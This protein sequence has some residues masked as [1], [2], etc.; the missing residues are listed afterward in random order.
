MDDALGFEEMLR[1]YDRELKRKNSLESKASYILGIIS[2]QTTIIL[3]IF[4]NLIIKSQSLNKNQLV[5]QLS[6][7]FLI[8]FLIVISIIFIYCLKVLKITNT[9]YP[10]GV[11]EN[12]NDLK[13][14]LK[15]ENLIKDLYTNYFGAIS[16][17]HQNIEK[18]VTRMNIIFKLISF[19]M[20][21][22]LILAILVVLL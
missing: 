2:M 13:S 16:F 3:S 18:N 1:I 17:N 8:I 7:L 9:A 14:Y 6:I 11:P 22:I 21:I 19:S 10:T 15:K 4:P 5:Y 20:V 12:I